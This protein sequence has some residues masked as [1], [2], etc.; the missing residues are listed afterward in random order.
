MSL[1]AT[2]ALRGSPTHHLTY[3]LPAL[4]WAGVIFFFSTELFS[5]DHTSVVVGPL[6]GA[7]LPNLSVQDVEFF[8]TVVRKVGHLS[9]YFILTV[10]LIRALA[11]ENGGETKPRHL[12]ISLAIASLYA[13]SDEFHQSFVPSRGASVVDVLIDTCGGISASVWF[14]LRK[15]GKT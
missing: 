9:E 11:N 8:H 13:I 14:Y 6:L 12:L 10:L 5:S 2:N 3:W 1:P 4:L 15:R 7:L